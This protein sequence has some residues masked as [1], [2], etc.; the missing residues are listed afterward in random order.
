M[1]VGECVRVELFSVSSS[2]EANETQSLA[3][4]LPGMRPGDSSPDYYILQSINRPVH[5]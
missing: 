3:R 2:S 1:M 4:L 5:K